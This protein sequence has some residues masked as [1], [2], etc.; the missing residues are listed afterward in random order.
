MIKIS[1]FK[2][3]ATEFASQ[4]CFINDANKNIPSL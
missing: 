1:G 4:E 2:K 3:K